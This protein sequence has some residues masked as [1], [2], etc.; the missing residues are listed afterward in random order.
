[1]P[2]YYDGTVNIERA[3]RWIRK[4][5]STSHNGWRDRGRWQAE[6]RHQRDQ[7]ARFESENGE[8]DYDAA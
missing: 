2:T 8:I 7:E 3:E 4:N 5:V 6:T 1:M